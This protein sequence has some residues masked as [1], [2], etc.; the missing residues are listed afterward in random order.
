[1][2][3]IKSIKVETYPIT[4]TGTVMQIGCER[5]EIKEWFEFD[6]ERIFEMDGEGA[7]KFWKKWRG[8]L[9]QILDYK[10]AD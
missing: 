2:R 8:L 7:L 1:M 5:H 6:D 10:Q 4:Y 3:E 9:I